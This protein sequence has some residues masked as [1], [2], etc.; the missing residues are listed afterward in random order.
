MTDET[1]AWERLRAAILRAQAEPT[2]E[3][4][5]A[6][7]RRSQ[8]LVAAMEETSSRLLPNAA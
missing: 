6:V 3:N 1:Q 2:E 7:R 4:H 5:A 8:R